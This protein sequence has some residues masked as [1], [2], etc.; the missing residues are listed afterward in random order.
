MNMLF[1]HR[2]STKNYNKINMIQNLKKEFTLVIIIWHTGLDKIIL[3]EKIKQT[4]KNIEK[5]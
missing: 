3:C 4:I 5:N 1:P 2:I